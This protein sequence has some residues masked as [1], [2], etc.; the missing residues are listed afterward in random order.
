MECSSS[1][2]EEGLGDY[3]SSNIKRARLHSTLSALLQDPLLADVPKN[4]TLS[5]VDT[6]ISLELGSA[7]RVSVLKLDGT[8]FGIVIFL[9]FPCLC[10]LGVLSNT[11]SACL[12]L[13]FSLCVGRWTVDV[14]VMNSATVKELKLAVK[15]KVSDAEQSQM[16][17]R[18]ISWWVSRL[19]ETRPGGL[20]IG[21]CGICFWA[22]N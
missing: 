6:L 11:W 20:C 5:D 14:A 21:K 10:Y 2:G 13:S 3:N 15:R 18:Q 12:A 22:E 1:K 8:S 16:G 4:P 19:L 17:H 7:M 9:C